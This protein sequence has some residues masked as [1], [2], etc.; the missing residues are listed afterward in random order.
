MGPVERQGALRSDRQDAYLTHAP[1]WLLRA[2][3]G[4]PEAALGSTHTDQGYPGRGGTVSLASEHPILVRVPVTQKPS[5]PPSRSLKWDDLPQMAKD[6]GISVATLRNWLMKADIENG[7][8]PGVT[9]KEADELRD[10]GKRP[11]SNLNGTAMWRIA[12]DID[13]Y[14]YVR[15]EFGANECSRVPAGGPV[16]AFTR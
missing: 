3:K 16:L 6:F 12:G 9:E 15:G 8:R 14:Y 10:A 11:G 7:A 4:R 2:S 5:E 13:I 1:R